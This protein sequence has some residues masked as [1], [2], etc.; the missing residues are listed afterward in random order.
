MRARQRNDDTSCQVL[1]SYEEAA[2]VLRIP[3][4]TLRGRLRRGKEELRKELNA[5]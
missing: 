2:D 4:T 3:I 5:E 1:L